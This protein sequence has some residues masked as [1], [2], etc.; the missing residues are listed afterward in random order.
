MS[1]KRWNLLWWP[2]FKFVVR[3][4]RG[5]GYLCA[6]R[7]GRTF[8]IGKLEIS[9]VFRDTSKP[10]VYSREEVYEMLKRVRRQ[11]I[12]SKWICPEPP[13]KELER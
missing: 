8:I 13:A 7:H 10:D 12:A 1:N 3:Q 5:G 4:M 9:T 2:L 11:E 6:N